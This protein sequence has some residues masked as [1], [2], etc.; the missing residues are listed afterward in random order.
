MTDFDRREAS[1]YWR[2]LHEAGSS[3][4]QQ[5][6]DLLDVV[7]HPGM[8]SWYNHYF[9]RTQRTAFL[10]AMDAAGFSSG[11]DVLEVGCG[12]ARWARLLRD[13]GAR[14]LATDVSEAVIEDNRRLIHGIDFLAGDFTSMD[15]PGNH[16]DLVVSVTV[17]QHLPYQVQEEGAAAVARAMKK[18]GRAIFLENIRD[19]GTHVFARSIV[20]WISLFREQGFRPKYVKGYEFNFPLRAAAR[21][22]HGVRR[23]TGADQL[24]RKPGELLEKMAG[25]SNSLTKAAVY[26]PVIAASHAVEPL[27]NMILPS[28]LA[29]HAA[30]VFER[31][32]PTPPS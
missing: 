7:C 32:E 16:F 29:T 4:R 27:S 23:E 2:A 28:H 5:E 22:I 19:R 13:R 15:L 14:V 3:R 12:T 1:E 10:R 6:P 30:M 21:L 25:R 26:G 8:P 20:D 11:C 18:G 9:A 24:I 17:L 31:V